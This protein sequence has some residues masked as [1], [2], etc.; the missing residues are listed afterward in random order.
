MD[1]GETPI[2]ARFGHGDERSVPGVGCWSCGDGD[3]NLA[4]C[5]LTGQ[6][7]NWWDCLLAVGAP[8]PRVFPAMEWS[9]AR[10]LRG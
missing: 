5:W 1:P 3:A 4:I 6:A 9:V 2:L 7:E 10:P 8:G